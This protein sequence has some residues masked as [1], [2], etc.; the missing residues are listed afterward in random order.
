[1]NES[2]KSVSRI[3]QTGVCFF[4]QT[5]RCIQHTLIGLLSFYQGTL[6]KRPC[7]GIEHRQEKVDGVIEYLDMIGK[8]EERQKDRTCRH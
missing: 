2:M 3:S 8:K 6:T 4:V 5:Y 1:M 7:Y